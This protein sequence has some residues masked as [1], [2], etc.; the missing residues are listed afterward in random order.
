MPVIEPDTTPNECFTQS[1]FLF[2]VIIFIG[3]RNYSKDPA[4]PSDLAHKINH[5]ALMA[6]KAESKNLYTV[7][8]LVLLLSW[9]PLKRSMNMDITFPLSGSLLHIAMQLGLHMPVA[10]HESSGVKVNLS[11]EEM[12]KRAELWAY[13][14]ITYQRYDFSSIKSTRHANRSRICNLVG[15]LPV[16]LLFTAHDSAFVQ[17]LLRRCSPAVRT[18]LKCHHI[19]NSCCNAL[20]ENGLRVM[21]EDRERALNIM[22]RVFEVQLQDAEVDTTS[23]M[24]SPIVQ[25]PCIAVLITT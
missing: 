16:A 8:A 20:M 5:M 6:P 7:K 17:V 11:E 18:Q 3:C 1:E 19:L 24:P 4:L 13:C 12:H 23:G 14:I 21:S 15:Q 10:S 2:W 25:L 9:H 22:I